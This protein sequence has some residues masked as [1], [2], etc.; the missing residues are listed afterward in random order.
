MGDSAF[1]GQPTKT[2][3]DYWIARFMLMTA[4]LTKADPHLGVK[5]NPRPPPPDQYHFETKGPG[6]IAGMCVAIAFMV[7]ITGT[8]LAI[9]YWKPKLQWGWDDWLIIPGVVGDLIESFI[10][11]WN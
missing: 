3:D 11:Q 6:I 8:R 2:Q 1:L 5:V 10:A 7:L 4:G 9:R